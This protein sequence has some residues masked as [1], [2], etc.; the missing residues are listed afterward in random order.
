MPSGGLDDL[1]QGIHLDRLAQHLNR[2][3]C[4]VDHLDGA[5]GFDLQVSTG[6]CDAATGT[7]RLLAAD[8]LTPLDGTCCNWFAVSGQGAGNDQW[9]SGERRSGGRAVNDSGDALGFCLGRLGRRASATAACCQGKA[10]DE[11]QRSCDRSVT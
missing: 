4:D 8:D 1:G 6:H 11:S 9:L 5:L 2:A 7:G 10:A 3:A